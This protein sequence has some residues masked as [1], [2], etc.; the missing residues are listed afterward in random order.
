MLF[1]TTASL[2]LELEPLLSRPFEVAFAD[3]GEVDEDAETGD[4]SYG[5]SL[6][7]SNGPLVAM[8]PGPPEPM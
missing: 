7:I 8:V 3:G 6:S 1:R 5:R 4:V 2:L